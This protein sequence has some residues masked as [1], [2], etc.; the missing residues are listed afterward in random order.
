MLL[1]WSPFI[2]WTQQ[3]SIRIDGEGSAAITNL[4]VYPNPSRDIFNVS[5]VSDEV[6]N[7]DISITNVIGEAIYNADL[8]QF[9]GQFT[10]EV[11]LA[12]YP[13]GVYFLEIETNSGVM[14]QKLILQ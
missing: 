1:V 9:V 13:K 11:S 12:T 14:K 7:L 5:F 2:Y 3:S 6:Q 4:E 10:K 8:E